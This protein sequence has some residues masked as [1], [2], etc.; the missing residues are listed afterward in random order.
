MSHR[1]VDML[2]LVALGEMKPDPR[3]HEDTGNGELCG[4]RFAK[5]EDRRDA[6]EEGCGREVGPGARCAEM[7]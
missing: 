6:A 4:D 2:M 5:H 3:C 7:P 1:F